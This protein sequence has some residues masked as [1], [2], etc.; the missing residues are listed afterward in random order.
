MSNFQRIVL[1]HYHEIGLKGHNRSKFETRLVRNIESLTSRFSINNVKRMSGRIVIYLRN[2]AERSEQLDIAKFVA[3]IP[4]VQRTS[5]GFRAEADYELLKELAITALDDVEDFESFKV[6]ARRN[7]TDFE[8]DSMT[9]NKEIGAVLCKRYP[10]KKVIMKNPDV[11]VSVEVVQNQS[12]VCAATFVGIG[13]L[14]AGVSGNV[15]CLLS[16]GIDS[17]V[18]TWMMAKRGA[19][20][21]AVHFSGR[22]QTSDASEYLVSDI[23]NK[24]AETGC[25]K[26]YWVCPI[27]DYQRK[28]ALSCPQE[29]RVIL[30]RRLMFRV[31]DALADNVGARAIVTGESLGQV[32]SQTLANMVATSDVTDKL[33][34]RPLIGL[35]KLE[36]INLA[37]K[38]ETFEISSQDAPDCCT[39]FMPRS[40]ETHAKLDIVR[41]AEEEY[42]NQSWVD[43]IIENAELHKL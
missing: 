19:T 11:V 41:K 37:E 42:F 30:Y 35:D 25:I 8:P 38:I 23:A 7:H 24:L 27:G 3:K 36:I 6:Q 21:S 26:Q 5:A 16:N 22:P 2:E 40:P 29:L 4:G 20:C 43:E 9:M 28:I 15:M 1:V 33:V 14:P 39:L 18:A 12:F 13:G 34:L 31:A 10:D 32:A 17:P